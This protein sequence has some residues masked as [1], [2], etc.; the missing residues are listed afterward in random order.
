MDKLKDDWL[1]VNPDGT[2]DYIANVDNDIYIC[3]NVLAS[4]PKQL[5][6]TNK[7]LIPSLRYYLC[8]SFKRK[9]DNDWKDI[10]DETNRRLSDKK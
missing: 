2:L 5:M 6:I 1:F 3:R 10:I 9:V 4:L 7:Q 8:K